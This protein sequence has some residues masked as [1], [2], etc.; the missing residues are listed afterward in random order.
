[1]TC[2]MCLHVACLQLTLSWK[3]LN[4]L[5]KAAVFRQC[6][7]L[8]QARYLYQHANSQAVADKLA[9]L[10]G[11]AIGLLHVGYGA[12]DKQGTAAAGTSLH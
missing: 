2:L 12:A 8:L 10:I 1:M 7:L 5:L 4:V 3:F 6:S 11:A 9:I